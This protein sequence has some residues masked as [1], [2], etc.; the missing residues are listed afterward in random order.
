[1]CIRGRGLKRLVTGMIMDD[2]IYI[3]SGKKG[4]CS[5]VVVQKV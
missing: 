4:A 3:G 1:M 5:L 2:G